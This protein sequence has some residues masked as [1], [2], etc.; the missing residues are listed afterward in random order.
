MAFPL[1]GTPRNTEFRRFEPMVRLGYAAKGLIY[2]LIGALALRLALGDGGRI[3]DSSGVLRTFVQQPFGWIL[4]M[5]IGVSIL[6]YTAWEIVKALLDVDH[7]GGTASGWI[8]RSLAIIKG[9]AY[10][11]IGWEALQLVFVRRVPSQGADEYAREAMQVPFGSWFI[12]LV[13]IGIAWYGVWQVWMAWKSRFDEDIDQ[14]RLR[15]EKLGWV[16]AVGRAGIGARGIIMVIMGVALAEAGF[17]R[18]P[19]KAS[20]MADSLWTLASQPFGTWLLAAVAAGLVC[21]GWFQLLHAR[22][23]RV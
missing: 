9:L 3:T 16:L 7:K 19:R 13:G 17:D 14:Q 18:S 6:A 22:Y 8:N 12:V 23:A 15:H 21:F 20:G 2:L 5:A 1:V 4:L 11:T 10:G